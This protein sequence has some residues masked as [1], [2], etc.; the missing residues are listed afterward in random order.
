[1]EFLRFR[2]GDL[3]IGRDMEERVEFREDESEADR[4]KGWVDRGRAGD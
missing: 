2:I 3:G 1:M 4:W